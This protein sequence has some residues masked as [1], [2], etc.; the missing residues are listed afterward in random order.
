MDR[1]SRLREGEL[2]DVERLLL[3]A[4]EQD[5]PLPGAEDQCLA[6]FG[7]GAGS[8][9]A[10]T[11]LHGA[12]HAG[13]A[14]RAGGFGVAAKGAAPAVVIAKWLGI[15]ALAGVVAAGSVAVVTVPSAPR[16][17]D[18]VRAPSAVVNGSPQNKGQ[19]QREVPAEASPRAETPTARLPSA[20]Q[21]Y[22]AQR[23]AVPSPKVEPGALAPGGEALPATLPAPA[24]PVASSLVEEVRSLDSARAA[25][26]AGDPRS[27][28]L[29]LDAHERRF[30]DGEL[31]PE[32]VVLRVRAL[33]DVGDFAGAAR[34]ASAFIAAHP[35]SAQAARLRTMVGER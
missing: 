4:A 20:S 24:A 5:R 28:L 34:V 33:R 10:A 22:P 11:S 16:G 1:L 31:E 23:L 27:A 19:T 21:P 18:G 26:A 29:R 8:A 30:P 9:A 6:L 12:A 35:D 25:L 17:A 13:H 2:S 14:A 15:G 3:D 7:V 32:G